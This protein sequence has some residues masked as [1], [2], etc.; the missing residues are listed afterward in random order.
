MKH[1][2]KKKKAP[3]RS[4]PTSEAAPRVA[5]D[6]RVPTGI[7]RLDVILDGGFLRGRLYLVGGVPGSGK[8]IFGNQLCFDRARAGDQSVFLTMLAE[9]HGG[10]LSH[11]REMGFFDESLVGEKIHY[12]SGYG[13][14]EKKSLPHVRDFIR[15]LLEKH[16]ARLLVID[17]AHVLRGEPGS[18]R[19]Y[20]RFIRE[21]QAV[22]S[23]LDCTTLLL[24]PHY[25]DE[26]PST[27]MVDGAIELTHRQE[28]PRAIRE[29]TVHK[30]RGSAALLGR[31]EVEISDRGIVIHPR[32]EVVFG[33]PP[34][35][36]G[37]DRV[38]VHFGVPALDEMLHGGVLS[39]S[40]TMLLGAPGTGKTVL[41]LQ[42]LAEGA[43]RN[44]PGVYFGFYETPPRLMEKAR[45]LGIPLAPAVEKGLLEIQWQ[46]PLEHNM[47]S[48]AERL[49][50]RIEERKVKHLRLFID[51]MAGFRDATVY[52]DRLR[53]FFAALTHQLREHDVTTII[54]EETA[55]FHPRISLPNEEF[56]AVVE[57]IV[58]LRH[59]EYG[60]E[61]RRLIAI[62]KSRES[63]YD[64]HIREFFIDKKGI[65]VAN[66]FDS[67][68]DILTG[69]PEL[70][71]GHAR[72]TKQRKSRR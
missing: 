72:P 12:F 2:K 6:H 53:R 65:S 26:E 56:A 68:S 35:N 39:S 3:A 66:T 18:E 29:L 63:E 45:S 40:T 52:P 57:N 24:V 19:A 32:T 67:A 22:S 17:G 60:N 11:L 16:D 54:S 34:E 5:R 30:F 62:L 51:G 71:S 37:E 48:L 31:H 69:K 64:P 15:H 41:G 38:R 58:L 21:L 70:I 61:L 50:E 59:V 36:A 8:T 25:S 49:L 43:R 7:P 1:T 44:E 33:N 13:T 55:L 47:D 42:F 14:F 4:A 10:M 9:S 20:Q 28:G 27:A 46:P 23:L